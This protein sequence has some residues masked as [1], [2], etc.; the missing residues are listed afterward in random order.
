MAPWDFSA[1]FIPVA[2]ASFVFFVSLSKVIS[3]YVSSVLSSTYRNLSPAGKVDWN[4][5]VSSSVHA[6]M[7]SSLCVYILM[8]DYPI[9]QDKIWGDSPYVKANCAIV[10][11]YMTADF[12][13][14]LIYYKYIGEVFY[15]FHHLATIIPYLMVMVYGVFNYF[16]NFRLIAEFSTPFINN[17]WFFDALGYPRTS[18]QY[19]SNGLAMST[20]FFLARI[21]SMPFFYYRIYEVYGTER[22]VAIGWMHGFLI[23]PCIIL[24]I[25]NTFWFYKLALGCKKVLKCLFNKESTKNVPK[26][27]F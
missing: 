26:K 10:I 22:Y 25:I 15:I 23:Y 7:V 12:V 8:F 9:F 24:D 5:R 16:A 20:V 17:R 13:L 21:L 19:V 14:I 27:D 18:I 6:A 11:G 4:S 3:P 2:A 1:T